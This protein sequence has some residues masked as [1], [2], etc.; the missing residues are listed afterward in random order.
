MIGL[1]DRGKFKPFRRRA[2]PHVLHLEHSDAMTSRDQFAPQR[3]KWMNM[4]GDRR[5][6]NSV[7]QFQ[8]FA[9]R[10]IASITLAARGVAKGL[11]PFRRW[12][13]TPAK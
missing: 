9:R 1:P 6:N 7:M 8:S 2:R 11:R 5:R 12:F 13:R 3:A 10:M 4:S